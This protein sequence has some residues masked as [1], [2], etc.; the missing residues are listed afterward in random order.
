MSQT[1]ST[2]QGA[3]WRPHLQITWIKR[4]YTLDSRE[5]RCTEKR[6]IDH[7][8]NGNNFCLHVAA[9]TQLI[10]KYSHI[11][12]RTV[13]ASFISLQAFALFL[14]ASLYNHFSRKLKMFQLQYIHVCSSSHHLKQT[15]V[16]VPPFICFL[17]QSMNACQLLI[18]FS[19][20]LNTSLSQLDLTN[21]ERN[22]IRKQKTD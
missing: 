1:N 2:E 20:H 6:L 12:Q 5:G 21:L 4:Y 7:S 14:P 18:C 10:I 3:H 8:Q 16:S 15:D 9:H 13:A 17:G 22:K 19:Y 11:L